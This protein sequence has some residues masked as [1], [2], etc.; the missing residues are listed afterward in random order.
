VRR[1]LENKNN[2]DSQPNFKELAREYELPEVLLSFA[3]D[4]LMLLEKAKEEF[5][6]KI[7]FKKVI[8]VKR[9]KQ[10][11]KRIKRTHI[12]AQKSIQGT[13]AQ[14]EDIRAAIDDMSEMDVVELIEAMED[15]FGV[16]AAV[17]VAAVAGGDAEE[18]TEFDVVMT[19]FGEK[20]V[21]VI[22]AVR[23]ATGL[24]LKEAKNLVEAAP[25]A[26][27]EGVQK[28]EAEELKKALEEAGAIVAIK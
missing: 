25:I 9:D 3:W 23:G 13:L 14:K 18:Q 19:S 8:E 28:A 6:E 5:I 26:L 27:K 2:K 7:D 10:A 11:V 17:A 21:A 4:K 1:Q 22:K 15:K 20:K 16:S 24:G 12:G